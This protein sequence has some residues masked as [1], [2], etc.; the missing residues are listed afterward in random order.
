MKL[1]KVKTYRINCGYCIT[2][3][4]YRKRIMI[5]GWQ[6]ANCKDRDGEYCHK[7]GRELVQKTM[8]GK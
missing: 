3:C 6:C 7:Y 1:F 4:R 2:R 8:G 5:G